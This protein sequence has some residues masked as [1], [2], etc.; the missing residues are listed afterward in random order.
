MASV[1]I[2]GPGNVRMILIPKA[3]HEKLDIIRLF[4]LLGR[5]TFV[6]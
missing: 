4:Y 3:T 1:Q 6:K 2:Y 5:V